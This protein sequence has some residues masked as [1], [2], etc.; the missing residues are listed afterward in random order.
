MTPTF[1]NGVLVQDPENTPKNQPS[2]FSFAGAGSAHGGEVTDRS[3]QNKEFNTFQMAA[4]H[5][6][7]N[8]GIIKTDQVKKISKL[9]QM[10]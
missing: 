7:E 8:N 2:E 4:L 6:K 5:A 3:R 1:V 10:I 9:T